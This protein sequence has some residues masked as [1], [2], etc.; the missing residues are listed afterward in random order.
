MPITPRLSRLLLPVLA[1]AAALVA[2]AAPTASAESRLTVWL[3]PGSGVLSITGTEVNDYAAVSR[4]GAS[5]VV[6]VKNGPAADFS[7][8]C[9][10]GGAIGDWVVTCPA[11]GVNRITFDGKVLHDSFINNTDLPSEAHGGPGIDVLKGGSGP[12]ALSG[13]A[14]N[15]M[16]YGNGGD[17]TIDGGSGFDQLSGGDGTDIASWADAT[18]SVAASL[19]GVANDGVA[20]E[21]ENV[22]ADVEG[23][24][25]G[26][27]DDKLSGSGAG[28]DTLRGGGGADDLEGWAGD[29][30]LQGEEGDDTLHP[31]AGADVLD[32]GPGTD[33]LSYAGVGQSVYVYQ[34]GAANDGMLGEHDNVDGIEHLTGSSYGDDLVGTPGDDVI[35]GNG[36]ADK[37]TPLF[38]D[39][40]IHGGDG[41]DTIDGGPGMPDDCGN[42]GCTAFDT[43]TVDGGSGNDT[44][45]YSSRSDNL[46]I[47]IDGS[48]K[49]GGFMENDTLTSIENAN[50][51][52]GDDTLY[53]N[54]AANSLLGGPG[55]DGMV[56]GKGND[57]LSGGPG[58]DFLEGDEGNDFVS[59][60]ED[61][62]TLLAAGGNDALYGGSG[63]DLVTYYGASA[64]VV[65]A[66]GTGT[67]GPAGEQDTIGS[68]VENLEGSGYKDK[69]TGSSGANL[70][71]GDGGNDTLVGNGGSDALQGGNGADT[72]NTNGDAL[73]DNSSCGAGADTANADKVDVVAGDC[74]TVHKG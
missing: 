54:A 17:D 3:A 51:G 33:T 23:L 45:D 59:G 16:L 28:N 46:T 65:A 14:D 68:D 57:Y 64:G 55:T 69:L 37:I 67:S 52:S 44:V 20:G 34:D 62:D 66:I 71:I 48:R 38:G 47:A 41:P 31:N 22:P 4:Q 7:A 10:E 35:K 73:K 26:A 50:G 21:N 25:G 42:Q 56:G 40:V 36:G 60:G 18:N 12:D 2:I 39:D 8:N 11:Q 32:G 70:L 30:V 1:G 29:D 74:E 27:Y 43:D 15:D 13:D 49:S 58:N 19:D 53:G 72:L 24:Q 61:A 63:T 9:T 6:N 5:L